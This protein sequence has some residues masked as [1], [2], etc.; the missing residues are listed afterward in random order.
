MQKVR[1]A[2]D[3]ELDRLEEK[4]PFMPTSPNTTLLKTIMSTYPSSSI[5]SHFCPMWP[6]REMASS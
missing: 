6:R 2:E 5:L 3:E 4:V 1:D